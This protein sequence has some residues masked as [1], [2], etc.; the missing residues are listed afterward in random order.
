MKKLFPIM[1]LAFMPLAFAG[2]DLFDKI[3]EIGFSTTLEDE[4]VVNIST[5]ASDVTFENTT[6]LDALTNPDVAEYADKLKGFSVQKVSYTITNYTGASNIVFDGNLEFYK[7]GSVNP[8][9]TLAIE[10]I[11]LSTAASAGTVY[12]LPLSDSDFTLLNNTLNQDKAI[13]F[14]AGGTLTS[15]PVTFTI[16]FDVEVKVTAEVL[17]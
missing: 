4:I 14:I 15:S 8:L 3:D 11:N 2:C 1:L 16:Q 10:N 12:E 17:D 7:T 5:T 6:T 13:K 9:V